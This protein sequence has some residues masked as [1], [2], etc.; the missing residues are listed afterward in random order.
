QAAQNCARRTK[1]TPCGGSKIATRDQVR[2][3]Q[4]GDHLAV[5]DPQTGRPEVF[6]EDPAINTGQ[7][8]FM[9]HHLSK[10]VCTTFILKDTQCAGLCREDCKVHG[11]AFAA[12][13]VFQNNVSM[14]QAAA[15]RLRRGRQNRPIRLCGCSKSEKEKG[16]FKTHELYGP[17]LLDAG[18]R[19][20]ILPAAILCRRISVTVPENADRSAMVPNWALLY[21]L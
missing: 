14:H 12:N 20:R 2:A 7:T 16:T 13:G 6:I 17:P 5:R 21:A 18:C 10:T 3:L 11:D 9:S 4:G 15:S 19:L 8:F 1:C